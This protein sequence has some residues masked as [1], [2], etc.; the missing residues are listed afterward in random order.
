V[1]PAIV[2]PATPPVE[3]IPPGAGGWAQS[4]SAAKR[5]EES[6][7]HASESAF[8]LRPAS[9]SSPESS[10][11]EWFYVAVSIATLLALLLSA[12]GLR[13]R[14]GARAAPLLVR[15]TDAHERVRRRRTDERRRRRPG[16]YPGA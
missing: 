11:V 10:G 15:S 7:K 1:P 16:A 6:R 8:T 4:P 12:R 14:S 3:P 2:P 5:R 13:P 9:A